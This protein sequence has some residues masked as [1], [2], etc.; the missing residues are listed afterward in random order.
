MTRSAD[1]PAGV[2]DPPVVEEPPAFPSPVLRAAAAATLVLGTGLQAAAWL[3][4]PQ[5]S[6]RAALA[7][8]AARS[9]PSELAELCL[10]LAIPFLVGGF[11]VYAVIGARRSPRLAW[12]GG[13]LM[14]IGLIE[15][16]I[17]SGSELLQFQLAADRVLSPAAVA[18]LADHPS[19]PGLVAQLGFLGCVLV[20]LPVT[21]VSLWRSA[22]VPRPAAVLLGVFLA[23]DLAGRGVEAHL[24]A[25]V[26]ATWIAVSVVRGEPGRRAPRRPRRAAEGS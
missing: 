3:I 2:A 16:G 10:V 15:L 17:H 20:G 14:A 9:G 7:S 6:Y 1:S 22:A 26:A 25:V 8:A 11:A 13:V 18:G 23:V 24:I 4:D 5:P 19:L 12:C 21:V